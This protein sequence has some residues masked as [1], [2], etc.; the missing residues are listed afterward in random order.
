MKIKPEH[1][2]FLKNELNKLDKQAIIEH[3]KQVKIENKYHDYNVRMAFDCL[4]AC[5]IG[6]TISEWYKYL[7]DEHLQ[8]AILKA[9]KELN[10]EF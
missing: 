6:D 9:C 5:K 1:Y 2:Q 3:G 8:T 7:N 10:I 4:Y